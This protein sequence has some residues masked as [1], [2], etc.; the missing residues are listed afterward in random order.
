M[1]TIKVKT[2][3]NIE[4]EY[5]IASIGDRILAYLIDAAVF[6]AWA[7]LWSFVLGVIMQQS[8][9]ARDYNSTMV[10]IITCMLVPMLFYTLLCEIF[11]NGQTIGKRARDIKVIKLS[12]HAPSVGDYLLRWIFRLFEIS[13]CYGIIAII[14]LAINGQGQ[15]LGDMAAGTSIIRTKPV[16]RKT[17]FEVRTEENYAVVFPEV[18]LLTDKDL[19]LIR[20]LL[21]KAI[22]YRNQALLTRIADRT[23][24]VI[25]V[26][27]ELPNDVFLKTV[28]KDYHHLMSGSLV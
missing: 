24:E 20:K 7:F 4:V 18:N 17:P 9:G 15:R 12:G 6:L 21:Y 11:M 23:K 25:G 5:A 16:R 26:N 2:T 3:Q 22:V 1:N 8:G 27:S 10:I 19:A 28:I 14:T 13:M